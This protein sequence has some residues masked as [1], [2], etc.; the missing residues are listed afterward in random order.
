MARRHSTYCRARMLVI[1]YIHAD[2][3]VCLY[4]NVFPYRTYHDQPLP[5]PL[6]HIT[7]ATYKLG[8]SRVLYTMVHIPT[9]CIPL[10]AIAPG[11]RLPHYEGA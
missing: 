4:R 1:P 7:R 2:I 6:A 3:D 10:S 8:M 9:A 5:A 11:G